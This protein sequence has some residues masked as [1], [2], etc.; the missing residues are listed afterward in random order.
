MARKNRDT[1]YDLGRH[2]V[3]GEKVPLSGDQ[4]AQDVDAELDRN[5]PM[6]DFT[7]VLNV[8]DMQSGDGNIGREAV[9]LAVASD[10]HDEPTKGGITYGPRFMGELK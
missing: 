2:I 1:T 10:C 8:S 3:T 7:N 9:D 4:F 5:D 6:A